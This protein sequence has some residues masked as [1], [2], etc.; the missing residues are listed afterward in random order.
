MFQTE[1]VRRQIARQ[2][3]GSTVDY[4][5][6]VNLQKIEIPLPPLSL[7]TRFADFVRQ[8]DK[9]KFEIQQGLKQLELQY[10]ALM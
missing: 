8:A 9:S 2:S 10:N 7:Q 3:A 1:S 6:L 4:L 5:S